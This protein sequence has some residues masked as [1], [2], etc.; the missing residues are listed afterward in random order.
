[1]PTLDNC[2]HWTIV[3]C[4]LASAAQ[5]SSSTLPVTAAQSQFKGFRGANNPRERGATQKH[6]LADADKGQVGE[7]N[8]KIQAEKRAKAEKARQIANKQ[9]NKAGVKFNLREA[10][11]SMR[12]SSA[13]LRASTMRLSSANL[14]ASSR[15]SRNSRSLTENT[16]ASSSGG[17]DR[18]SRWME[19]SVFKRKATNNRSSLTSLFKTLKQISNG[20]ESIEEQK[21]TL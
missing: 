10:A 14:R 8:A 2:P 17:G 5:A 16:M 15:K 20:S 21:V 9:W 19:K 3:Q 12:L 18:K 4:I 7:I 11:K 1:M 6:V 13:N